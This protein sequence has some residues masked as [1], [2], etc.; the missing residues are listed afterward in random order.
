MRRRLYFLL[1]SLDITRTVHNELL[2]ARIEERHIHVLAREGTEL[3]DLPSA[4]LLQRSDL[5]HGLEMGLA[6]GGA[7]GIV[8]GLL[9]IS[10]PPAGL[11]LGGGTLLACT[12]AGAGIGAW[13]SSMISTDVP[14]SQLTQ[15]Q[16][17]I[18]DG[19]LLLMIDVPKGEVDRITDMIHRLHPE[20]AVHGTEPTIP[21]FP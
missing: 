19:Q 21:A 13:S 7:T 6:L 3:E 14:N 12:L 17:A 8:A 9:A 4:N 16:Q 18:D 5:L 15:F 1:P 11:N 2:L 20:A 10:F